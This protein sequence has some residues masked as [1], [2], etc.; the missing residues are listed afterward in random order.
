MKRKARAFILLILAALSFVFP[1]ALVGCGKKSDTAAVTPYAIKNFV[2]F[3]TRIETPITIDSEADI[4]A[5]FIIYEH[6]SETHKADKDVQSS[7]SVLDG[8]KAQFDVIKAEQDRL[9][10]EALQAAHRSRFEKAVGRLPDIEELAIKDK[11]AVEAAF[12]LYE[13]LDEASRAVP[14]VSTAYA[15]LQNARR[16]IA[17]L[18]HQAQLEEMRKKA[19]EF[20][21]G[22][23]L[24]FAD[25]DGITL[26]SASDIKYLTGL[27]K[28]LPDEAKEYENVVEAKAKLD[29]ATEVYQGLKDENDAEAFLELIDKL[30]EAADITLDDE[31]EIKKAESLYDDMSEAAKAADGVPEAYEKLLAA[32]KKFD[33]L[34]AAA[35]VVRIQEFIDAANEVPE[36]VSSVNITWYKLLDFVG[37]KYWALSRASQ[38][39]PEVEAAFARWDKA[40][41]AFDRLG[42]EQL[43]MSSNG[44]SLSGDSPSHIVFDKKAVDSLLAFF[45]VDSLAELDNKAKLGINVY[46]DGEYVDTAF[47]KFSLLFDNGSMILY[48]NDVRD[49]LKELSKTNA[50]VVSGA[51]YSFSVSFWDKKEEYEYIPSKETKVSVSK[52][53]YTW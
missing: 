13:N 33:I 36:N 3:V 52:N 2:N 10:A 15:R 19:Q 9:D 31:P 1:T 17:E 44:I 34:F 25:E 35:E 37:E 49:A 41:T 28:N 51:N 43:P 12:T 47:V 8:Y 45:A 39:L 30:P 32:R 42:F 24:L 29:E 16:T 5:G 21:D 20:V 23:E 40:Q 46:I 7:K 4:D 18:E 6:L 27:Y 26:E 48:G 50:K 11:A 53:N 22:V 14:S 38:S